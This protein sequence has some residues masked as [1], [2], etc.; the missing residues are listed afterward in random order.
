MSGC[1]F[2]PHCARRITVMFV[3]FQGKYKMRR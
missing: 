1:A 2:W 3:H